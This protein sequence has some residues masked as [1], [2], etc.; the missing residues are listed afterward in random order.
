MFVDNTDSSSIFLFSRYPYLYIQK[1]TIFR[2]KKA[3]NPAI[4]T[5]VF[6]VV[7]GGQLCHR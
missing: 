6:V 3:K 2:K 7:V 1:N 5:P 4:V